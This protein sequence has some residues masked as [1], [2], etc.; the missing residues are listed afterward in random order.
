MTLSAREFKLYLGAADVLS[1]LEIKE[2]V[3]LECSSRKL[4]YGDFPFS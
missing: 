4:L 3:Y 2:K 1:V